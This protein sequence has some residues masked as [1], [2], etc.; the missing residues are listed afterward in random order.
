MLRCDCQRAIGNGAI[1]FAKNRRNRSRVIQET[2]KD[3]VKNYAVS[4]SSNLDS[5][6]TSSLADEISGESDRL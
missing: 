3:E 6:E 1:R 4:S 5:S 2:T